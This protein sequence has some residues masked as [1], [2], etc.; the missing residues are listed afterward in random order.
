MSQ[1]VK[2]Q[3]AWRKAMKLDKWQDSVFILKY[4]ASLNNLHIIHE[5]TGKELLYHLDKIVEMAKKTHA[6]LLKETVLN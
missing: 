6:A 5:P 2:V 4:D 3:E 1:E